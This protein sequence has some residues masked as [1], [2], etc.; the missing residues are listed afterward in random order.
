M[1][2]ILL[3]L[4]QGRPQEIIAWRR[5]EG[6]KEQIEAKYLSWLSVSARKRKGVFRGAISCKKEKKSEETKIYRYLAKGIPN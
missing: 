1:C 5:G 2:Q 6:E 3:L 4:L